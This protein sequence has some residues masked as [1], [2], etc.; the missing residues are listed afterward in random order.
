LRTV[1]KPEL[2][3]KRLCASCGA[4]FY[5]LN[6]APITCPKCGT[7]FEVAPTTTRSRPDQRAAVRQPEAEVEETPEAEVISLEE[8][9]AE[10]QGKKAPAAAEGAEAT[11][12]ADTDTEIE[13]GGDDDTFIEEEEE[14]DTDVSEIIGG[15]IEDEE[16]T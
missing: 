15:D 7:P 2:G 8:A 1:A 6:K 13:G 11:E 5:D 3:T 10:Q 14:E 16:E 4:K 9:D 12:D